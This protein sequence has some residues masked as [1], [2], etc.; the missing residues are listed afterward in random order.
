MD[1]KA[2]DEHVSVAVEAMTAVGSGRDVQQADIG[3]LGFQKSRALFKIRFTGHEQHFVVRDLQNV[4]LGQAPRDLP[5]RFV[6]IIPQRFP[7]VGIEGKDGP[8][9]AGRMHGDLRGRAAG[10]VGEAQSAEVED[11]AVR[12]QF[13]VHLLRL[14]HDVRTGLA[15]EAERPIPPGQGMDIGQRGMHAFIPQKALSFDAAL[16]DGIC[17]QVPEG[18]LPHLADKGGLVAQVLEHGQHVAGRSAGIH[19]QEKIPLGA[20][21]GLGEIDQKL[22]QSYDVIRFHGAPPE[23]GHTW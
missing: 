20:E 22:A 4:A 14:Q 12:K 9:F 1:L 23:T 11:A 16:G 7:Q 17:Q 6:E 18:V 19:L 15:V 21:T 3:E 5:F 2:G 8:C 13:L 10:L